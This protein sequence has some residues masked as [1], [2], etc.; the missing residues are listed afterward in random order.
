MAW[1]IAAPDKPRLPA[2]ASVLPCRGSMQRVVVTGMGAVSCLG[3][4]LD[5]IAAALRAGRSGVVF[6]L[7]RKQRGFRSGLMTS[8]PQLDL[9]A[10]FDRKARKFM[11]EAA[12]HAALAANR[13]IAD[14]G[15]SRERIARDDVGVIVGND[16]SCAPLPELM[17]ILDEFGESHFLGSD[18][19][20]KVMNSTASMNLGPFLGARGINLTISAACAS[21][22]HA[23]GYA[24]Q[25]IRSGAQRIVF[26]GGT[27]E[28]NWLSMVS[29]DALNSFSLR[30]HDPARASRPFDRERDGL[31]PGGGG[32]MLVLES[33]DSARQ[34]GAR[35]HGEIA[36]YAFSSDGDH[37]T[38]PSGDGALRC[39]RKALDEAGLRPGEVDYVNAHATSTVLGDRA[40]ATAIHEL[41]GSNGPPV[42]STKS[43]TG[44][45]CWMAGAS[46][47]IY[48]AL[49]LRDG[50]LAPNVNFTAQ[51]EET[52]AIA[53]LP[54]ARSA[55]VDTILSN[56]F[57]FGGTNACVVLRRFRG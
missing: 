5:A 19:V 15:L 8:L 11:P 46:E 54:E 21:G 35:I 52:P 12:I 23:V 56:S 48:C 18:M 1:R 22:A 17:R 10:E 47:L 33:L 53:V 25:L 57:G 14:S 34:R 7:E 49:M 55:V 31:V 42:S 39:M 51:D 24:F 6:A 50:F 16:S 44:H 27:Q 3:D 26:A 43:M 41:F 20:I 4:S 45:E 38:L 13:A 32:A 37:L 36:S 28:T 29:F 2:P 9:K 40:E 30:E